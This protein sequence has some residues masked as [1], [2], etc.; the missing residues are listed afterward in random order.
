[1]CTSNPFYVISAGLFLAGLFASFEAH[2]GDVETWAL[3]SGLGGYTMLLAA[4]AILLVRFASAWQDLRTVL[5]LVVLMFLATSVTFDELIVI[6]PGRGVLC[7]AVGLVFAALVSEGVLRGIRLR[8]PAPYRVPYYLL[9]ALFF[10]YPVGL[11]ALI[12]PAAPPGEAVMWGLFAF[13]VAAGLVFLTLLPSVRRGPDSVRDNGSP[14][15]WPLYPWT[16]F[17]MLG[18]GVLGRSFLLCWSMHLLGNGDR[19]RVIFGPYFLVPFGFSV[20]LLLLEA[21]VTFRRRGTLAAALVAPAVL[22]ILATV[23]HRD[24]RVYRAFLDAFGERLGGSPLYLTLWAATG[25]YGY[26]AMRRAPRAVDALA[27]TLV[28]LAWVG[29]D[30]FDLRGLDWRDPVPLL[31]AA[32]LQ[33]GLGLW[34]YRAWRCLVGLCALAVAVA[35]MLPVEGPLAGARGLIAFHGALLAVLLVGAAFND[36]TAHLLRLAGT[37]LVLVACLVAL[38]GDLVRLTGVPAWAVHAYPL[39]MASL[40]AG[41]GRGLRHPPSS[42]VAVVVASLWGAMFGWRGYAALR[43]VVTGLDHI[44]LSLAAFVLAVLISLGKAGHLSRWLA[45]RGWLLAAAVNQGPIAASAEPPPP[46]AGPPPQS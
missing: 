25:Y 8:L 19:Q 33:L 43:R 34:R 28:A 12:D 11:R 37:G 4:T 36:E 40:L 14:W 1:V 6:D 32:A 30:T 2:S 29:P 10:L 46:M 38:F 9:L 18:V 42:A 17:G 22:V 39:V 31:A 24:D 27:A 7:A 3:M 16:L 13:P 5:L 41:Y 45:A 35:L 20:A 23:G 15:R 44:A 26:A 21:G